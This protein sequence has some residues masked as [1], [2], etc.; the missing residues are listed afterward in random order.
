MRVLLDFLLLKNR[1]AFLFFEKKNSF[2]SFLLQSIDLF[3]HWSPLES[4]SL[5]NVNPTN[6]ITSIISYYSFHV[7][8]FFA[9]RHPTYI[10]CVYRK[11]GCRV[12]N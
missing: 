12:V 10:H 6:S 9:V 3:S 7:L 8:I 11:E 2:F 1:I 4:P 5:V